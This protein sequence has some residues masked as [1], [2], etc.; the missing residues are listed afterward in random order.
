MCVCVCARARARACVQVFE[1]IKGKGL[2][3]SG[4]L[5]QRVEDFGPGDVTD[6]VC[7]SSSSSSSS[8]S[9]NNNTNDNNNMKPGLL[10]KLPSSVRRASSRGCD[11][12]PQ[13]R[14]FIVIFD[15]SFIINIYHHG[16]LVD[17]TDVAG[18]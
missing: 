6:E 18:T 8:S 7:N 13:H 16:D 14:S 12:H 3:E 5:K 9:S 15:I 11:I 2:T 4:K 1:R 10:G 17:V